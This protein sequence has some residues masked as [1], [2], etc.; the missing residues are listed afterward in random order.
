M[1]SDV[2]ER[3][4]FPCDYPIKVMVRVENGVRSH[5][6]AIVERHAGPL[7]LA[8][9]T[10]R[11]SAQGNFLGITY[12]IRATSPDQIAQLFAALKLC[13]QVMLVL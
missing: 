3:L 7:D 10:E 12:L 1:T 8:T 6:D 13:P 9:V 2:P 11:P 4:S 5:V